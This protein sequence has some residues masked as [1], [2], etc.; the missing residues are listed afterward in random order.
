MR[1]LRE[2]ASSDLHDWRA[3]P[4]VPPDVDRDEDGAED[5]DADERLVGVAHDERLLLADDVAD[6]GQ[7]RAPDPGAQE[8]VEGELPVVHPG[9]AGGERDEVAHHGEEP[10][11]ERGDLA[12]T[13]EEALDL[14]ELLLGD[15][16]VFAVLQDQRPSQVVAAK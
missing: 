1:S 13:M 11:D 7:H 3:F 4:P 9:Q 16:D 5:D 6:G 2:P 15:P 10:A 8:G 14:G 12:V